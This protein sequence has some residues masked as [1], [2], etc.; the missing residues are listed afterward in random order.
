MESVE[1]VA[2][3]EAILSV[4]ER[5]KEANTRKRFFTSRKRKSSDLEIM[6]KTPTL[7]AARSDRFLVNYP[8]KSP[9]TSGEETSGGLS[10]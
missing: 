2:M 4:I 7:D 10:S 6:P 3:V 8:A 1:L 9:L 5:P